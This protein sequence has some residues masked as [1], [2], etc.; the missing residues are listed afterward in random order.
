MRAIRSRPTDSFHQVGKD[1]LRFRLDARGWIHW[2]HD[3]P[4]CRVV[5]RHDL[6]QYMIRLAR[7]RS[8][9]I[10]SGR[11][12]KGVRYLFGWQE[13]GLWGFPDWYGRCG[14]RRHV[15]PFLCPNKTC[16]HQRRV[17]FLHT[18]S[19]FPLPGRAS[20]GWFHKRFDLGAVQV[21]AHHPMPSRP[22]NR[23]CRSSVELEVAWGEGAARRITWV[24]FFHQGQRV[25]G[26]IVRARVAHLRQ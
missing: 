16:H 18:I 3:S 24:R 14:L 15:R 20:P 17:R 5:D 7:S 1:N 4:C 8:R 23:V 19:L 11:P 21:R 9:S 6:V 12:S 22:T 2:A 13:F 10:G 26:T 25:D